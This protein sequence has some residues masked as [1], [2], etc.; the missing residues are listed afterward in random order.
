MDIETAFPGSETTIARTAKMEPVVFAEE[1]PGS[2][3]S[4]QAASQHLAAE[5]DFFHHLFDNAPGL[6]CVL[7]GPQHIFEFVNRAWADLIDRDVIGMPVREALHEIRGQGLIRLLDTVYES[8][9]AYT[10]RG[11]SFALP[12]RGES[13]P[14]ERY[15]DLTYQPIFDGNRQV[16]GIFVSGM[17]ATDRILAQDQQRLLMDELNHR[18]KNMLATVCAI[19]GNTL[20]SSQDNSDFVETFQSRLMAL[21][22]THNALT[23][24]QWQGA[25]LHDLLAAEFEPYG[26]GQRVILAGDDLRLTPRCALSLG[27]VFHE[28][29]INAVK[30]GALSVA[31][32]RLD[33]QWQRLSQHAADAGSPLVLD[34]RES[35]GP[36]VTPPKRRGFGSRLIERSIIR[37]LQGALTVEYGADGL[38]YRMV[39]PVEAFHA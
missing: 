10:G 30:Y 12:R 33:I 6:M 15:L 18:V 14:V 16:S 2:L 1:M 26:I 36:A 34:W 31:A 27:M 9:R 23:H 38:H 20:R 5:Y 4:L 39:L 17:D 19:A 29:A 11:L 7:R 32:G 28:L 8:G 3:A 37:E 25:G 13:Q 21:S 24:G 22:R 35:G